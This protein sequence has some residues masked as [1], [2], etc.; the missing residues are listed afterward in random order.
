MLFTVLIVSFVLTELF[1]MVLGVYAVKARGG[2][3]L[4]A[5]VPM[6]LL[7]WPLGAFAAYKAIWEL[8]MD[9]AYWDK[10]EHGINDASYQAEIERL[11]S[12]PEAS[13]K[14]YLPASQMT[15]GG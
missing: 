4:Y 5:Y 14:T 15:I 13:V 1:L 3:S 8:F 7:Y 10:T 2:G 12:S 6:M 11:T 9:P